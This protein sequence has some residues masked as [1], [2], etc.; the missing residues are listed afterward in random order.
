MRRKK[1]LEFP[2]PPGN[3]AL[4]GH[5]VN[6][7]RHQILD[8]RDHRGHVYRAVMTKDQFATWDYISEKWIQ[9]EADE[10]DYSD[11]HMTREEKEQI[12]GFAK[13]ER[14]IKYAKRAAKEAEDKRQQEYDFSQIPDE[15]KHLGDWLER[16][17]VKYLYYK[18]K[19]S[20]AQVMCPHCGAEYN[21]RFAGRWKEG[22]EPEKDALGTCRACGTRGYWQPKGRVKRRS[23]NYYFWVYQ[24]M[25][26]GRL[27]ARMYFYSWTSFGGYRDSIR[28][29]EEM[30][31]IMEPGKVTKYYQIVNNFSRVIYWT[32]YNL[33]GYRNITPKKGEVYPAWKPEIERSSMRYCDIDVWRRILPYWRSESLNI[34]YG[35]MTHAQYPQ[36]EILLKTGAKSLAK[37]IGEGWKVRLNRKGR[38]PDEFLRLDPQRAKELISTNGDVQMLRLLQTEQAAGAHWNKKERELI[39]DLM[40]FCSEKELLELLG[41][42]SVK[43]ILNRAEKYKSEFHEST[44]AAVRE[45]Y[46]YLQIRKELGYDLTNSVYLNPRSLREAHAE[47][48]KE[49]ERRRDDKFIQEKQRQYEGIRQRYARLRRKYAWEHEGLSIRPAKDAE[50][51]IM[52]GRIQHHCVGGDTYLRRHATGETAILLLRDGE[53]PNMPYVTV[54]IQGDK[55]LQWYGAHD[56]KPD[57]EKIDRWLTEYTAR[58]KEQDVE[59]QMA[60]D[61]AAQ[62]MPA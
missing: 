49:R 19:G 46:D 36:T 53:T 23:F 20:K 39:D 12:V 22:E 42:L 60:Q 3:V 18:K 29:D 43:K 26:D 62:L 59:A 4:H 44:S 1:C 45:L 41:I 52:E 21:Y 58:L 13:K 17:F 50:E 51:I 40:Y 10:L 25:K 8:I 61:A 27:L 31:I 48:I 24:T 28:S 37:Q 5:N 14:E 32:R 16:T 11:A 57:K 56:K 35:L 54:E 6:H 38:R 47:M 15:P 2:A 55:I 9:T 34:I 33:G 7:Q 30:R